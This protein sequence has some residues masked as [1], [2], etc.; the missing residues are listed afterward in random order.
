MSKPFL[1]WD[2]AYLIG[3]DELDFEHQDLFRR[4]NELYESLL[5]RRDKTEIQGDL[6]ELLARVSRHFALEE[7]FMRDNKYS[8]YQQ[9]KQEHDLFLDN[10]V[11]AMESFREAP[12]IDDRDQLMA[13]LQ[14]WIVDHVLTSDRP[15]G[16]VGKRE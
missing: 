1:E 5:N 2:D 8:G 3:V 4:L 15:L 7:R 6:G 11:H 16:S 12:G 10:I 13:E 14:R 9:H